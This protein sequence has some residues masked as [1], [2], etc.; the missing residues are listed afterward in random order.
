M[1]LDFLTV[2]DLVA[3]LI[4]DWRSV[5]L[6]EKIVNVHSWESQSSCFYWVAALFY[7]LDTIADGRSKSIVSTPHG[8]TR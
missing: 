4:V 5:V 3:I 6:F 7:R 8:G 2:S 1:K